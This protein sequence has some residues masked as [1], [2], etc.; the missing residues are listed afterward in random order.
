MSKIAFKFKHGFVFSITGT[1]YGMVN[2]LG[3]MFNISSPTQNVTEKSCLLLYYTG[4]LRGFDLYVNYLDNRGNNSHFKDYDLL[5]S[6]D[7]KPVQVILHVFILRYLHN[8]FCVGICYLLA[9][10]LSSVTSHCISC[11][12]VRMLASSAVD[13]GYEPQ[14]C[15]TKIKLVFVTSPMPSAVSSNPVH[16]RV[17]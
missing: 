15:Q 2:Y 17:Y 13:R 3:Y 7:W 4:S 12:M 1:F 11:V 16:G 5:Q 6:S 14:S 8:S 9:I 10:L